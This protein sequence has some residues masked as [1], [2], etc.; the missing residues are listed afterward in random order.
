MFREYTGIRLSVRVTVCVQNIVSFQSAGGRGGIKLHVVRALV[1]ITITFNSRGS[2][3][4]LFVNKQ[5]VRF[6]II[7]ISSSR[8]K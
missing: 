5:K 1:I 6:A 3:L 2:S 4:W 8:I 7:I